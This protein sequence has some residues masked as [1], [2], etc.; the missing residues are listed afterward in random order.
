MLSNRRSSILVVDRFLREIT[1]ETLN[2]LGTAN[3][4]PDLFKVGNLIVRVSPAGVAEPLSVTALRGRMDR[5]ADYKKFNG[6]DEEVPARPP[7]DVVQDILSLPTQD[8]PFHSLSGVRHAPL[9]LSCGRLLIQDGFDA[10]SGWLLRLRGLDSVHADM[11]LQEARDWLDELF[12]DFPFADES[13]QTHAIA[14]L[15]QPFVRELI[16][17]P[18]PLYLVDA[19]ARGTGK[20]LLAEI[21]TI[22]PTGVAAPVM[23]LVGSGDEV[24]KRITSLLLG[25]RSHIQL[26]NVKT[27]RSSHLEAAL[28]APVWNGRR[29]GRSE[30]VYIPNC[31]TWL[32]TGNNVEVS[33]EMARRII[34]IRLDAQVERPEDRTGFRRELPGWAYENRP[35]LVSACLS[36]VRAWIDAGQPQGAATLGRYESWAGVMGGL[37]DMAGYQGCLQNRARLHGAADTETQEWMAAVSLWWESYQDRAITASGLFELVKKHNLLLGVWGNRG[38]TGA[39]Q[40]IGHALNKKRDRV[41]GTYVIRSAGQD[42]VTRSAAYRLEFRVGS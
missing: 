28:T 14:L 10:A 42:G 16:N 37:L 31:A 8:I 26:D 27:L 39:L 23:S 32:A 35:A 4:P 17:S 13:S 15:L 9:F 41:L 36:S 21:V 2:C 1:D 7:M 33:D 29:L 11:S 6:L 24:E 3:N 30:M 18:T 22:V 25:G 20:G 12:C 38:K 5:V 19:P 40:R 34:P